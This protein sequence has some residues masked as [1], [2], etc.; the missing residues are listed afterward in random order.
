MKNAQHQKRLNETLSL[1]KYLGLP[2][3]QQ[4]RRSALTLLALLNMDSEKSWDRA[5]NPKLG[6]TPIMDWI[7]DCYHVDYAPNTR[8][9]IR[10]QTIHQFLQAGIVDI[11]PDDK[12]RPINSP[13]TVYQID[14][15]TLTLIKDFK[16]P[17]WNAKLK[18]YLKNRQSLVEQYARKRKQTKIPLSFENDL[19]IHISPGKHSELIR[20]I[21]EEFGPRF[22]PGGKVVYIGDTGNKTA[23]Q[24]QQVFDTLGI[25]LDVHGKMP[26][27]MLYFEE[28]KWLMIIEAASTHGPVNG[29]RLNE[30]TTLFGDSKAKLI[31]VT[32]FPTRAV[33]SRFLNE[34]AWETEVWVAE[35]PSHL[36]HF[37]GDRFLGPY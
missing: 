15:A 32:A 4:N 30:L 26:D 9:T 16:L 21:I 23:F 12:N 3:E 24:N 36:I 11:N 10:R 6:I 1:L 19:T 20:N 2:K 18:S 22:A 25:T 7:R 35:A 33:M 31:F 5:D 27:V 28:K 14:S 8:E 13:H 34:I 29:K 37:N 17:G